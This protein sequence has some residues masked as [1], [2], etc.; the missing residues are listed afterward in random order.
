V[1][2]RDFQFPPQDFVRHQIF[3]DDFCSS[4]AGCVLVL[5][6]GPVGSASFSCMQNLALVLVKH[7]PFCSTL[8]SSEYLGCVWI[9]TG[10]DPVLFLSYWIK[11]L[12]V[13]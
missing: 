6:I 9:G 7:F 3:Q 13:F 5:C 8:T 4:S 11:K 10:E 12:E 1:W 2:V